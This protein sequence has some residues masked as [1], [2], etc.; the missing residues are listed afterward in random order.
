[1]G[2]DARRAASLLLD[3]AADMEQSGAGDKAWEFLDRALSAEA[4]ADRDLAQYLKGLP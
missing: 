2:P 3:A 1:M 4:D